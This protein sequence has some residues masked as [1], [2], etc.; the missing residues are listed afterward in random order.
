M[1]RKGSLVFQFSDKDEDEYFPNNGQ[2]LFHL[3]NFETSHRQLHESA[4]ILEVLIV[5]KP[6]STMMSSIV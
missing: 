1:F 6:Q 2:G 5:M 3:Q 4:A